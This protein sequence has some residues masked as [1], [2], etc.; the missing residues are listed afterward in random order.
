MALDALA[1]AAALVDAIKQQ[2]RTPCHER[3]PEEAVHLRAL[4]VQ[5][6][7]MRIHPIPRLGEHFLIREQPL[8]QILDLDQN[9]HKLVSCDGSCTFAST[10]RLR[11]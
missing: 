9:R 6:P 5:L 8:L 4:A 2:Q 1:F 3:L 7:E 10:N 11:S